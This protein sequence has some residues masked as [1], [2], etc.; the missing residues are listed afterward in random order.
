M[1]LLVAITVAT[2]VLVV[3]LWLFSSWKQPHSDV[4]IVKDKVLRHLLLP[5][6]E[7]PALV[8]VVDASKLTSVYLKENAKTGDKVLLYQKKRK[9]IIYRPSIDRIVDVGVLELDTVDNL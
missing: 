6:G 9:I 3:S 5:E 1:L 8:S 2:G 7:D 4:G